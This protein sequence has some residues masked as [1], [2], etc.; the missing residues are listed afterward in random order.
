MIVMVEN[1]CA[2]ANLLLCECGLVNH[3]NY[4]KFNKIPSEVYGFILQ[5]A[6]W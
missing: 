1:C 5:L 4:V 2:V 6:T 3:E